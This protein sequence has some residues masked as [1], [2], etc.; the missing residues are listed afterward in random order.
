M[1]ALIT[2]DVF[3]L[4]NQKLRMV[5]IFAILLLLIQISFQVGFDFNSILQSVVFVIVFAILIDLLTEERKDKFLAQELYDRLRQSEEKLIQANKELE[6]QNMNVEDLTSL[7]ERNRI[8][9]EIHDSV[10]HSL[11]TIIIQLGAISR[12][13]KDSPAAL[14]MTKNLESFTKESLDKVRMVVRDMKPDEYKNID[15][16]IL[17]NRLIEEHKKNTGI[18]VSFSFSNERCL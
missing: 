10:G 9:R 6:L 8:S 2:V 18:D 14:A 3:L 12:L 15:S 7:K 16:V 1:A 13:I 11:P 17:I 4:E 5:S